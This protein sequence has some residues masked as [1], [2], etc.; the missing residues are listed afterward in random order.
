ML[1]LL[2]GCGSAVI[3]LGA[4]A[5][6]RRPVARAFLIFTS[7]IAVWLLSFGL[8]FASIDQQAALVWAHCGYLGIPLIPAAA[9]HFVVQLL[10]KRDRK[11][12]AIPVLW[13]ISTLLAVLGAGTE[14]VVSGVRQY[15]WGWYPQLGWLG[16]VTIV[17][18]AAVIGYVLFMF[19]NALP[20]EQSNTQHRRI[21]LFAVAH[22]IGS[23]ALLDSIASFGVPLYPSGVIGVFGYMFFA[24]VIISRYGL[25]DRR[26]DFSPSQILDTM[27]DSVIVVDLDGCIRAINQGTTN[28][29][30]FRPGELIGKGMG[31][32]IE[33]P[34]NVGRASDTLIRGGKIRNRAMIWRD[35]E[36]ALVE[37]A[38]S[39][40]ALRNDDGAPSGIVY[41]AIDIR[42]REQADQIQYQ[43]YH[44][45][46]TGLPN[47]MELK[48]Q[49]ALEIESATLDRSMVAVLLLDLDGFKLVN[50]T[51]GHSVGD[52]LLQSVAFRIRASLRENDLL[53]R[54][55]GDEF[56]V[57]IRA[58]RRE[59]VEAIAEKIR[60]GVARPFS[61]AQQSL[62]L[63]VSIGVALYP[64]D[65]IGA[66]SLLKNADNAMYH[67]KDL[68]RNNIQFCAPTIAVRSRER[69][70]VEH[71]LR[72]AIDRGEFVLHYQ[73]L[74]SL[75]TRQVAGVEALLRWQ[76]PD[77]GLISPGVFIAIAEETGLIVPIGQW[78]VRQACQD[79]HLLQESFEGL[80]LGINL[81][82]RQFREHDLMAAVREILEETEVSPQHVQFEI[83]ESVAMRHAD[84]TVEIL[85]EIKDM[86]MKIAIDDFGTGYSSLSYLKRF[87]IDTLKL[88]Q[89]FVAGIGSDEGDEAIVSAV[90]AMSRALN[91]KVVAEGVE[92]GEQLAFLEKHRCDEIQGYL[93]SRP[94]PIEAAAEFLRTYSASKL[95]E[96][97]PAG[98]ATNPAAIKS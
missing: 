70:V 81:S 54:L 76:H 47:R 53:A 30:G 90:L 9:F 77:R 32:L 17:Y 80:R 35:S 2:V 45:A 27:V 11:H 67:A 68:G 56:A 52:E 19:F 18:I 10:R 31:T 58:R 44:D 7:S 50:E 16:A 40:A 3:G 57:L 65:G 48:N 25:A 33:S 55:G 14:L 83:T 23:F 88:D 39:G 37:V 91:L 75:S 1:D 71:G 72:R 69:L 74:I 8:M 84:I 36:G 38:V 87:P 49:L 94:L 29:F 60:V 63:T 13:T 12:R 20:D 43:A 5:H 78:V 41:T 6:E 51:L 86:G 28:L 82:A 95:D 26:T 89:S 97:I 62:Y 4:Y 85:R 24:L 21:E 96:A 66:E 64:E 42:D 93:V 73:P 46:L 59:D 79:A 92:T 34:M 98:A 15:W 22:V 61:L